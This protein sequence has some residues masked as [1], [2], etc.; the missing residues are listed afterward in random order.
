MCLRLACCQIRVIYFFNLF[1]FN[2]SKFPFHTSTL[3]DG[4]FVLRYFQR[5]VK[6]HWVTNKKRLKLQTASCPTVSFSVV[7]CWGSCYAVQSF[8]NWKA[9][10]YFIAHKNSRGFVLWSSSK[11][12]FQLALLPG[13]SQYSLSLCHESIRFFSYPRLKWEPETVLKINIT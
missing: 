9:R 11:K 3:L 4:I 5:N 10:S 7:D 12:P 6:T 8:R 2:E 13:S 1:F